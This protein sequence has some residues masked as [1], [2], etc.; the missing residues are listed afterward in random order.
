MFSRWNIPNDICNNQPITRINLENFVGH[1]G[2]VEE[3]TLT[4]LKK[5]TNN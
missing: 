2:L 4:P 3:L 5:V 1:E